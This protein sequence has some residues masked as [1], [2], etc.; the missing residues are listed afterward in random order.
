MEVNNDT[1]SK[2][3]KAF[4][5]LVE[6][7][8]KKWSAA[9]MTV[10]FLIFV[11]ATFLIM[12]FLY[13]SLQK[14]VHILE[15]THSTPESLQTGLVISVHDNLLIE[16]ELARIIFNSTNGVAAVFF[17]FHNSKTDLQG[18]HDFFYS[19]MNEMSRDTRISFLPTSRDVP[20]TRLGAYMVPL[21]DH[22]C[23]TVATKTM[24]Q[25]VWLKSRLD[26][27]GVI[28]FS[29]CPVY[30]TSDKNLLGFVELIYLKPKDMVRTPEQAE[31]DLHNAALK[32]SSIISK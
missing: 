21:L 3:V 19:A 27:D 8:Q 12:Y 32:I 15:T 24:D 6:F 9:I 17:K 13:T 7:M 10:L 28:K 5:E 18:K 30:D 23:Q 22:K 16:K 11:G 31:T 1:A 26:M 2:L 4:K 14:G 20:I 29:A 25:N